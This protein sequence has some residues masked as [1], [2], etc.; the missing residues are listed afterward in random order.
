MEQEN[1]RE[2]NGANRKVVSATVLELY[3]VKLA[4]MKNF[5]NLLNYI[6]QFNRSF[7]NSLK[8]VSLLIQTS[9]RRILAQIMPPLAFEVFLNF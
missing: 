5:T 3:L 1:L 4:E 7:F 6:S 8:F 9:L 2:S